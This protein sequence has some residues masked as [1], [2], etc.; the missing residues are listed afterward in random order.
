[1]VQTV[2]DGAPKPKRKSHASG[3]NAQCYTPVAQ[4]E[5]EVH[6]QPDQ[7]EEQNKAQVGNIGKVGDRLLWEDMLRE[8]RYSTENGRAEQDAANDLR[9]D[10]RLPY[11]R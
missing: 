8:T 9:D 3:S 5:T 7:E 6:L 2:G 10:S 11:P 4:Q 1:M